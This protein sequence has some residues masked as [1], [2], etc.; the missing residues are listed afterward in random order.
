MEIFNKLKNEKLLTY[1]VLGFVCIQPIIELDLYLQSFY[2]EN[3]ILAISTIIRTVGVAL[4]ALIAFIQSK[5]KVKDV[6]LWI[7]YGFILAIYIL[8]HFKI[9]PTISVNLPQTYQWIGSFELKYIIFLVI[10]YLIIWIT[11]GVKITKEQ[12]NTTICFVSLFICLN[13]FTTNI[14]ISS[15]GSYGGITYLNMFSWFSD[16]A[17]GY[18][19]VE[20]TSIGFYFTANPISGLLIILF[21]LVIKSIYE[22]EKK[23]LP[24][25]TMFIQML[26]MF[27]IGTRVGAFGTL[28]CLVPVLVTYLFFFFI[29]RIE[30]FDKIFVSSIVVAIVVCAVILPKSP[31]YLN[32]SFDYDD[33]YGFDDNQRELSNSLAELEKIE[34]LEEYNYQLIFLLENIYIY[35]LTFPREYY[36]FYYPYQF[37]PQFYFDVLELPFEQRNG[38]RQFQKYFM[39]RKFAELTNTQK[40][41]GLGYSTMAQ[42]GIL[43]EQDFTRQY[44]ALGSIGVIVTM[45]PYLIIYLIIAVFALI[46]F[47]KKSIFNFENAILFMSVSLGLIISYYSGHVMDEPIVAY[48]L[49]FVFGKLIFNLKVSNIEK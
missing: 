38:G 48:I 44:Y 24:L 31:A 6:V 32:S 4:I 9:S 34:N 46:N 16:V 42:G 7:G 40:L 2:D 19:P 10:P 49:A 12:F 15:Y 45:F 11:K 33:E 21:P 25:F 30:R 5:N 37:D 3:G 29:K 47:K 17:L 8:F 35:Y 1:L 14:L 13:I 36:E 20:L 43:I 22:F 41:S 27:M 18:T 28:L 26:V 39:T 23:A